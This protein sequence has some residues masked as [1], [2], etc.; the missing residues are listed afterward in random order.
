VR[1]VTRSLRSWWLLF[2]IAIL[3]QSCGDSDKS[4]NPPAPTTV[5]GNVS[6][7]PIVG[8]SVA[9][10]NVTTSGLPGAQA[11]GPYTTDASGN[12]TGEAPGSTTPFVLAATG[13]TYDDEATG[14]PVTLGAG[15]TLY[16]LL[17][18]T[19]SQVTPLTH[20]TF[21]GVRYLVSGSAT[22][23]DAINQVTASSV[24][25]FGFDFATTVPRNSATATDNEKRY[26]ALLGG[27]STLPS[28]H[29][30]LFG[31]SSAHP[32]DVVLALATDMADGRLDGLDPAGSPIEV[33]TPGP[34]VLATELP[35]L[36]PNDLSA[37]LNACNQYAGTQ[38]DLTG[39]G[40]DV[41]LAWH[42]SSSG[43]GGDCDVT[44]SGTGSVRLHD[45]CFGATSSQLFE[46]SFNWEDGP[47]HVQI[48][49]IPVTPGSD[50]IRTI[51]VTA[52]DPNPG[53]WTAYLDV[54]IPGASRSGGVVTFDHVALTELSPTPDGTTLILTGH[55]NEPN[56]SAPA[57]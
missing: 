25:A 18:G 44:F 27:F 16:G 57:P 19:S 38:T 43:G 50:R 13:G 55:L 28:T 21:L 10:L 54:G 20:T 49:A 17:R 39:I 12:W 51:Y 4:T 26:A 56:P 45:V 30:A 52:P 6:K 15:Q 36:S 41:N 5:G 35:A 23:A 24:S 37:W 14:N 40:F 1:P 33:P 7:G 3:L 34:G 29:P 32:M 46:E 22:L 42:P 8:A 48:L 53:V 11:A 2:A 31:F 9:I 47:D